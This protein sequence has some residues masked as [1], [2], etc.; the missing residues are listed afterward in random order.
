[1]FEVH[2]TE[3]E[4]R[5]AE[6]NIKFY[7]ENKQ[8]EKKHL[9]DCEGGTILFFYASSSQNMFDVSKYCI[10]PQSQYIIE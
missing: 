1:M 8:G 3:R 2:H 10:F 9:G 7:C 4:A 5:M 6:M